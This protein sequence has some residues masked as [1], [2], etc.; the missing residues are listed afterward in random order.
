MAS[1]AAAVNNDLSTAEGLFTLAMKKFKQIVDKNLQ[2]EDI[3]HTKKE[4]INVLNDKKITGLKGK[5][6]I[7]TSD[8]MEEFDDIVMIRFILYNMDCNIALILSAGSHAPQERLDNVKLIFQE[9]REAKMNQAMPTQNGGTII[10][11]SDD[12]GLFL[13]ENNYDL[14]V[15]CGP[16]HPDNLVK[17]EKALKPN[18]KVV[19][20]GAPTPN[21]L[22]NGGMAGINQK[23]SEVDEKKQ[24]K[25]NL[26]WDKSINAMI[27]KGCIVENLD[28]NFS[29]Y[30]L[31]P[32]PRYQPD[33]TYGQL[34]SIPSFFDEA[35][36]STGMFICSRPPPPFAGRVNF[37]NSVIVYQLAKDLLENAASNPNYGNG[38]EN[39]QAYSEYAK[40]QCVGKGDNCVKYGKTEGVDDL[41]VDVTAAIPLMAT[42]LMGGIR[43]KGDDGKIWT[44]GKQIDKIIPIFMGN[45]GYFFGSGP[46]DR[47]SKMSHGWVEGGVDGPFGKSVKELKYFTPAYDPLAVLKGVKM[48]LNK[49]I[50]SNNSNNNSNTPKRQRINGGGRTKKHTK[51]HTKKRTKKHTK[52]HTKSK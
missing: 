31:F 14:F 40:T 46:D 20:V 38:L 6:I 44:N 35:V 28:V 9:F 19:T 47:G 49:R 42:A 52:K 5:N 26:D 36:G 21:G 29:R 50:R 17:I 3:V 23:S 8:P 33:T 27:E 25:L 15:N 16:C 4:L 37:G 10:F 51:K 11:L 48:I 1:F 13:D 32:N 30:V 45:N 2:N 18:S 7:V 24:N 34:A 43:K 39:I 12:A 22:I 41:P